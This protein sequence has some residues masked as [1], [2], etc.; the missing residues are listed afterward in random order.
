M[1]KESKPVYKSGVVALLGRPNAGKST[2]LNALLDKKVSI[3]SPKPQT[4][5]FS[6][7]AVYEDARGQII[8][9]THHV[10]LLEN[11]IDPIY[12]NDPTNDAYCSDLSVFM[13]DPIVFWCSGHTH[14][15]C[16][17]VYNGQVTVYSNP[18]GYPS[19]PPSTKKFRMSE[20]IHI[21]NK[22]KEK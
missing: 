21:E 1:I 2:L 5:Q 4:T 11:M 15:P 17:F 10:P 19:Q 14:F 9:A 18:R 7:Q 3:T 22:L 6:V 12:K 20:F 8:V 16:K 13:K